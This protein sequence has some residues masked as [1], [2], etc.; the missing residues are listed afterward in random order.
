VV[1]GGGGDGRWMRQED[2]HEYTSTVMAP[3]ATT[4]E[5]HYYSALVG[6][7]FLGGQGGE[8]LVN[9]QRSPSLVDENKGN[10]DNRGGVNVGVWWGGDYYVA[11]YQII[12][13]E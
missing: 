12:R 8:A 3:A 9:F 11:G 5:G 2:G 4:R 1:A 10:N 7:D 6:Q 13:N